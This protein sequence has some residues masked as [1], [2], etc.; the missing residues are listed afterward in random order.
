MQII[1]EINSQ[2]VRNHLMSE[3]DK[4]GDLGSLPNLSDISLQNI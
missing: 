1:S 3:D 4:D 2:V